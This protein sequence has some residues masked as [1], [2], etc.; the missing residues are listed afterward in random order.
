MGP[1]RCARGRRRSA[2]G[3]GRGAMAGGQPGGRSGWRGRAV[4]RRAP[5][6]VAGRRGGPCGGGL[7]APAAAPRC[8]GGPQVSERSASGRSRC[9][10]WH[11]SALLARLWDHGHL[12]RGHD[13]WRVP[14]CPHHR[15]VGALAAAVAS[16]ALLASPLAAWP[17]TQLTGS[18]GSAA[19]AARRA[20]VSEACQAANL[21]DVLKNAGRLTLSTDNPAFFPWLAGTVPEGSEWADYGGY[22]PAGEGFESAIAYAIAGQLGFTPDQVDWVAQA[23]FGLAF[24]PGEKDFDFHL[25]QVSLQRRA[26]PGRR[27]QRLLLRRPAGHRGHGG[28]PHQRCHHAR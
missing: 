1:S 15:R 24:A 26:R 27:L 7:P 23:T 9:P 2:V 22:P 17:R 11:A 12:P 16:C 10:C 18:D 21:G 19:P 14:T 13:T 8:G 20:T 6:P 5:A 4:R 25:G 28:Q 3:R